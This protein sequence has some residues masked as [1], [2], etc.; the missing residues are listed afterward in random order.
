MT[1]TS[2]RAA[3]F[4]HTCSG[5]THDALLCL[6]RLEEQISEL[7]A[8]YTAGSILLDTD[9]LKRS[10]THECRSW[11]LAFGAALNHRASADMNNILSFVD[12]LTKRLQRPISDLDDVRAA[13]AALREVSQHLIGCVLRLHLLFFFQFFFQPNNR[14]M[15]QFFF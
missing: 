11:K 9:Q 3:D 13:M 4:D 10:L 2:F 5:F 7:P 14:K 1:L 6:Q 8:F 12:A 15:I